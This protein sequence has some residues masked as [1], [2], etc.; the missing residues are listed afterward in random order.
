MEKH[1][2]NISVRAGYE[3]FLID[4]IVQL[5]TFGRT[6][7]AKE[8]LEKTRKMFSH[9]KYRRPLD[10]FVLAEL[11]EDMDSATYNQAQAAVQ[12]YLMRACYWLAC[13][14]QE[15]AAGHESIARIL[16]QK[17]MNDIGSSSADRRGLPELSDM[18]KNVVDRALKEFPPE[19]AETLRQ[20]LGLPAAPAT[21]QTPPPGAA[22]PTG[23]P[24]PAPA[25]AAPAP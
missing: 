3:N 15:Q 9:Q 8:Y 1:T 18:R 2:D 17:Y 13:G 21:G 19:L 12:N 23:N 11:K 5:Y 22:A 25:A 14:D 20:A 16:W 10:D 6:T 4:A 24:S 7:K